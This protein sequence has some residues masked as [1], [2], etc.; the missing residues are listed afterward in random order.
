MR[1]VIVGGFSTSLRG[2]APVASA[3]E[4]LDV[5]DE[6]EAFPFLY[7]MKHPDMIR[8]AAQDSLVIAHSAGILALGKESRP[9]EIVACNGPEVRSGRVWG[10]GIG[11]KQK[12]LNNRAFAKDAQHPAAYEYAR[13]GRDNMLEGLRHPIGYG[14]RIAQVARFSTAAYLAEAVGNENVAA[15]TALV[16]PDDEFFPHVPGALNYGDATVLVHKGNHDALL[17]S[18]ADVLSVWLET[19]DQS[20]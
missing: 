15:A 14:R 20:A 17:A 4:Q 13:I 5:A 19:R 2:L 18:P 1:A 7:A 3:V 12:L 9:A 11:A 10:L 16:T 8:K 6:I